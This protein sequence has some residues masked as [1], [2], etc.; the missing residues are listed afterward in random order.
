VDNQATTV[1]EELIADNHTCFRPSGDGQFVTE[2]GHLVTELLPEWETF[3]QA[4]DETR[5]LF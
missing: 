4:A 3:G 2:Q 1:T 5:R